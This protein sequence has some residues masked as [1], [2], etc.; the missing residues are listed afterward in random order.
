MTKKIVNHVEYGP[1]LL[2]TVTGEYKYLP[3]ENRTWFTKDNKSSRYFNSV[4]EFNDSDVNL[5]VVPFVCSMI[6]HKGRR[7][8]VEVIDWENY[9]YKFFNV[10]M[11]NSK[12]E[13]NKIQYMRKSDCY[14]LLL[15]KNMYALNDMILVS[16]LQIKKAW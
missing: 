6:G 10:E 5:A 1:V 15:K 8:F 12:W 16:Y 7:T 4:R 2:D 3:I 9:N 13:H 14:F 11:I